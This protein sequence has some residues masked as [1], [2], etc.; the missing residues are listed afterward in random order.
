MLGKRYPLYL[1]VVLTLILSL[2]L[3]ACFDLGVFGDEEGDHREYY[4]AFGRVVGIFDGGKEEY[5][6]EASLFNDYTVE[7]M[8][9][10][11]E[12]DAVASH[13][14]VYIVLPFESALQVESVGLFVRTDSAVELTVS[15]FYFVNESEAPVKIKFRTSPE[16]EIITVQDEWGNDVEKEV[17]IEYDDPPASACIAQT[18]CEAFSDDWSSFLLTGFQQEGY[19]DGLLHTGKNG[20]LY[21]RIENNSGLSPT[22]ESCSFAFINLLV[23]AV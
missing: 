10:D 22:E 3:S 5:D 23:R 15:A 14:Y 18:T 4:D 21:I 16:T 6:V 9:W 11:D 8:D 13:D 7:K 1:V 19:L 20:L 17:E 12:E 2:S